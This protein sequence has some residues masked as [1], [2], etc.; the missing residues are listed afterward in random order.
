MALQ[1][2]QPPP[3]LTRISARNGGAF[4]RDYVMGAIDGFQR[5]DHFSG[6]MPAFGDADLG[7]LVAAP[8]GTPVPAMLLALAAYLEQIQ[9]P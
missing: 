9:T 3:D 5:R 1:L 2:F 7:P 6:A 8:D 4:P